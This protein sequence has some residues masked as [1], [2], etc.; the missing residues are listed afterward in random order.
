MLLRTP[1][2]R[3]IGDTEPSWDVPH[4]ESPRWNEPRWDGAPYECDGDDLDM[5]CT[6]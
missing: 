4:Y 5:D 6:C 1:R 2:D 3:R